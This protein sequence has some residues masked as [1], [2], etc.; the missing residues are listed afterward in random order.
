M[1]KTP[2]ITMALLLGIFI[3][4]SFAVEPTV[5]GSLT[6]GFEGGISAAWQIHTWGAYAG[7][8]HWE[9]VSDG[10]QVVQATG[11][12]GAGGGNSVL[13][14]TD[15]SGVDMTVSAKVKVEQVLNGGHWSGI[16]ARFSAS[17]ST[18]RSPKNQ[19]WG[20]CSRIY[21]NCPM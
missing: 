21:Y 15:L 4:T 13:Y 12:T 8:V 18:N 16:V 2:L 7:T 9:V 3:G 11:G 6:D 17:P 5:L 1:K 14:R 10:T 19:E 20:F